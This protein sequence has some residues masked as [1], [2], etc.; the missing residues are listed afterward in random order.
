MKRPRVNDTGDAQRTPEGAAALRQRE[1]SRIGMHM[2]TATRQDPHRIGR[3]NDQI[4]LTN[5][6]DDSQ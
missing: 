5:D 6:R 2:G 3:E 4:A 1:T